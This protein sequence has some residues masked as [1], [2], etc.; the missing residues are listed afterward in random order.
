MAGIHYLRH[1]LAFFDFF[2]RALAEMLQRFPLII[3]TLN[4]A[5]LEANVI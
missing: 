2:K 1:E 5:C 4:K 3:M